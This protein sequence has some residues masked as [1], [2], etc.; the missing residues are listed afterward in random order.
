[1]KLVLHIGMP[2]AGSTALQGGLLAR[3]RELGRHGIVYPAGGDLPKNHNML[4]CGLFRGENLPRLFRQIYTGDNRR[5]RREF[6]AFL[7]KLRTTV[8][9]SGADTIILSSEMMFRNLGP[10]KITQLR[11]ILAELA[12][13]VQIVAYVRSPAS[14]Y[15]SRV[16]Q[17]IKATS[18][19]FPFTPVSYRAELKSY[20]SLGADLT[21]AVYDRASLRGGDITLDF[22]SRVAPDAVIAVEGQAIREANT[23]MSAE[24]MDIVQRYRAANH[25]S[26][27]G[28]FTPDTGE[29]LKAIAKIE[30]K[31]GGF[32]KPSAL[33]HVRD[34]LERASVDLLWLRDRFG[35][36]FPDIDYNRIAA[37]V[38]P[39]PP[40]K[41]I[42][43]VCAF[44]PG[45][46]D[47]MAM[48]VIH[49]L[50]SQSAGD[51]QMRF[52][53]A[54]PKRAGKIAGAR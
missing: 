40:P 9:T 52:K 46:R 8:D 15:L 43:D 14:F 39:P 35:A 54:M 1:M 51:G 25:A 34:Y 24:G 21:V 27:D 5:M 33:D 12:E 20:A 23:S 11:E 13:E 47:L 32:T 36:V 29:V 44:D 17:G 37:D 22:L 49:Q 48:R 19:I 2:K 31:E 53:V 26:A 38:I 50:S 16:Q 45:L 42:A 4:I 10:K 7:A 18:R 6:A 41:R 30:A 3:Q 28:R